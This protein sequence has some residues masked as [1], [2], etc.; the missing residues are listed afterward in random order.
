MISASLDTKK[1]FGVKA[2]KKKR[3]AAI[4]EEFKDATKASE[5]DPE[6]AALQ[7][8]ILAALD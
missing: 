6:M 4:V 8:S 5:I 7:K 1:D 3:P 2:K